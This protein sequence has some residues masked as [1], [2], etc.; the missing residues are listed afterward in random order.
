M[1]LKV[2]DLRDV[3]SP[4]G[5]AASRGPPRTTEMAPK[6]SV[7]GAGKLLDTEGC[8]CGFRVGGETFA[9]P[10]A[11]PRASPFQRG[12]FGSMKEATGG[13]SYRAGGGCSGVAP[14]APLVPQWGG[15]GGRHH[16]RSAVG[17]WGQPEAAICGGGF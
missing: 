5:A 16:G 8:G 2:D 1:N 11:G 4:F 12:A 15:G 14:P 13:L 10:G 7:A 17:G 3:L 9:R 6:R